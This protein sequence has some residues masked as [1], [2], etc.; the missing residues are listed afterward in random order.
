V[1][2]WKLENG[3]YQ[4]VIGRNVVRVR[5]ENERLL[6]STSSK[7]KDAK[8]LIRY[9][10]LDDDLPKILSE[11]NRDAVIEKVIRK[12]YGLRLIRQDPWEC[13]ISY[14]CSANANIPNIE[15]MLSKLSERFGKKCGDG[16]FEFPSPE[17]FAR[18]SLQ[19]LKECGVGYRAKYIQ[20]TS[21]KI[22]DGEISFEDLKKINY[23]EARS[24][25]LQLPGVGP[26]VADC[27]LLFSLEK[28]QAFPVDVWMRKAM[29]KFYGSHLSKNP[30]MEE[31]ASF[32]RKY[33]GEF[34]GYAQEYLFYYVR[35]SAG[36]KHVLS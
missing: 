4:G 12:N 20:E 25:L 32:G 29:V 23:D 3:W 5:Q 10:R 18:A 28:L 13:L 24:A 30:P 19:E 6:F 17:S 16:F 31:I 33:F 2:R 7:G 27:V 9:F 22:S 11:I 8:F 34:A 1:F 35:S 14:I 21:R 36:R 15:K 26:K